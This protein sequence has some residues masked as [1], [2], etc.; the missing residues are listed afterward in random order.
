METLRPSR[1]TCAIQMTRYFDDDTRT[2]RIRDNHPRDAAATVPLVRGSAV[3]RSI[4][5][6]STSGDARD[7]RKRMTSEA[8]GRNP[9]H[10]P[11]MKIGGTESWMV[12]KGKTNIATL[13]V[14]HG[15]L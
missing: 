12:E 8:T 7:E 11:L 1:L 2:S 15:T 10:R 3:T 13:P 6:S 9:K 14:C 5:I 4:S